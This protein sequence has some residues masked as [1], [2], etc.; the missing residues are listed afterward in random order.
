M[1]FFLELKSK[2]GNEKDRELHRI[3]NAKIMSAPPK[4]YEERIISKRKR[5]LFLIF[6]FPFFCSS[7]ISLS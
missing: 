6:I 1:K 7:S 5:I 3:E 2:L 4:K